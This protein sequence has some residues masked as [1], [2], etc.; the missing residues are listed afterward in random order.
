MGLEGRWEEY[1]RRRRERAQQA[2]ERG[3]CTRCY[4]E[5]SLPPQAQCEECY[6]KR[7]QY[8]IAKKQKPDMPKMLERKPAAD[9]P[10]DFFWF[11]Q[12]RFNI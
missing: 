11:T 4:R 9:L 3:L 10:K 1:N 2:K 8:Q 5:P 6:K 12:D 7:R